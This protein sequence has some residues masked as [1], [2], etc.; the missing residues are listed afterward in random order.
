VQM[1]QLKHSIVVKQNWS[2]S[3]TK[4]KFFFFV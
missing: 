2:V 4:K 1:K 3:S